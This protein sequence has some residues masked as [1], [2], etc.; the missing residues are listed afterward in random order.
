M[1]CLSSKVGENTYGFPRLFEE[2]FLSDGKLHQAPEANGACVAT[3]QCETRKEFTMSQERLHSSRWLIVIVVVVLSVSVLVPITPAITNGQADGNGHPYVGWLWFYNST[4]NFPLQLCSGSLIAPTV[5]L[6]A[7]HCVYGATRAEVFF[8]PSPFENGAAAIRSTSLH[9]MTGADVGIVILST[10]VTD[11]GFAVL[12][13]LGLVDSLPMMTSITIVGFGAS[14]Q[15]RGEPPHYWYI[16]AIRY[17]AAAAFINNN[18]QSGLS[19]PPLPDQ[20]TSS[21]WFLMLTANPGQDKGGTCFGDSGGPDLLGNIVL[22][23]NSFGQNL[24][25]T[26]HSY[27]QRI[28]TA[29]ALAFIQSFL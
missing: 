21:D 22:A 27:G 8:D 20:P 11:K 4:T 17:T 16:D 14:E 29:P 7:G 19:R 25:C 6:T 24:N 15:A 26:G 5:V 12:P 3:R 9:R 2:Q 10:P 13:T 28:D 1:A 23:V 18:D